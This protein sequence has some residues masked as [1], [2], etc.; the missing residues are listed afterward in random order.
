MKDYERYDE[1][2]K[3]SMFGLYHSVREDDMDYISLWH[4]NPFKSTHRYVAH[5]AILL[6]AFTNLPINI[7]CKWY[8]RPIW[9]LLFRKNEFTY[10]PMCSIN[11]KEYLKKLYGYFPKKEI[12]QVYKAYYGLQKN[13]SGVE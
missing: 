5:M 2:V 11:C 13:N 1:V 12:V 3:V 9:N 4:I 10:K 6:R 8:W 7:N